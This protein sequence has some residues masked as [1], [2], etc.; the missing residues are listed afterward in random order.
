MIVSASIGLDS[1]MY[2]ATQYVISKRMASSYKY[3][4][5]YVADM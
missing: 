2:V 3:V 5:T 4:H 1:Y